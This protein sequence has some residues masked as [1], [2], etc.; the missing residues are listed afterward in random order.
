MLRMCNSEAA[1]NLDCWVPP[2]KRFQVILMLS[3]HSEK[4]NTLY[5][6]EA[7]R[8]SPSWKK[9]VVTIEVTVWLLL[10]EGAFKSNT[11][12]DTEIAS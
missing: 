11:L 9:H 12:N 4:G 7:H 10:V 1:G 5:M 3:S 8:Y 6:L 2:K